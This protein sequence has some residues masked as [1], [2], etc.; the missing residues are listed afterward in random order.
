MPDEPADPCETYCDEM[1]AQCQGSAAQYID[2][3]Q[4]LRVCR[5]FPAGTD[6]GPDGPDENSVACRLK[7]ARKAHYALGSEVTAYCRQAGP[8]GEGRC[9]S[10][11]EGFCSLMATVCTPEAAGAY[12]FASD[13]DCRATCEALPPASVSYSTSDPQIADGN[14][15]LCRLF[16]VTSAA[17]ADPEEHCEHAL[18][19]TLCEA[20]TP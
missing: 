13:E 3:N 14:H 10:V 12:H 8:S 2:R 6:D 15:A 18:G 5:I 7:Y 16:H 9:G 4:C 11:C 17:M 1:S 20:A 19:I